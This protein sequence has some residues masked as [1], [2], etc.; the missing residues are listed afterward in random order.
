MND[1]L[2]VATHGQEDQALFW[3]AV[4]LVL[5]AAQVALGFALSLGWQ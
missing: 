2:A 3:G 4:A 1:R 5:I